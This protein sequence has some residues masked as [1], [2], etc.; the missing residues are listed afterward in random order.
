MNE[1]QIWE[2]LVQ[3]FGNNLAHPDV[4]PRRFEAQLKIFKHVR[5]INNNDQKSNQ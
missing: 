1:E 5:T 2:E 3:F 4:E